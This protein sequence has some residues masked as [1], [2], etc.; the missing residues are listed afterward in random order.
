MSLDVSITGANLDLV[1]NLKTS[2]P[3]STSSGTLAALNAELILQVD[4]DNNAM[5][6]IQS[7]NFIGTLEFTGVSDVGGTQYFPIVAYTYSI[8]CAGGTIPLAGQPLITDAL[9][10]ANTARVYSIPC[11]QLK[12]VRVRASAFTS[13]SCVATLSADDASSLNTA[14]AAKPSTLLITA[15]GAASAAVTATLPA[16]AGL[17]HIIDFIQVTRSATAALTASAT[18]VLVT[19]TNL[20]G[21]PAL[22]FGS[23]VAGVGIDKDVRLDF[24]STGLAASVLGTATTVVCPVYTGVI[25]RINVGYRLG[26]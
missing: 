2:K 26:L 18:P 22:T 13:G 11:G 1:G 23:D 21:A 5:L 12:T 10:A 20:P 3:R 25:W 6:Y 7:T 24:G 8:G 14:I 15:T 17:R 9:V 19:T 4:S 16:V